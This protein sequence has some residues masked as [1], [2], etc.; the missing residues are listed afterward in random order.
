VLTLSDPSLREVHGAKGTIRRPLHR[1][2][3]A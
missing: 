2:V 3:R 1:L